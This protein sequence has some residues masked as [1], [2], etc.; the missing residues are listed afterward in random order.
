M[1]EKK[2]VQPAVPSQH[3]PLTLLSEQSQPGGHPAS[4][5]NNVKWGRDRDG[6]MKQKDLSLKLRHCF[7]L[8]RAANP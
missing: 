7:W 3:P 4:V 8:V 2:N 1:L 5:I 6:K